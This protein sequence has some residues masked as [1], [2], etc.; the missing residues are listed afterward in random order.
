[1]AVASRR[2]PENAG[3]AIASAATGHSTGQTHTATPSA[4]AAA[5]SATTELPSA[6]IPAAAAATAAVTT[7]I[8]TF[9]SAVNLAIDGFA[10]S[11]RTTIGTAWFHYVKPGIF[12]AAIYVKIALIWIT[13]GPGAANA[14]FS[15]LFNFNSLIAEWDSHWA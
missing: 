10:N 14:A 5:S 4:L 7:P 1:M 13:E 12:I 8:E 3:S 9:V 15:S 11:I 2:G 6:A